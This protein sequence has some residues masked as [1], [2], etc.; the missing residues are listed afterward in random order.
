MSAVY[1]PNADHIILFGGAKL[2]YVV[3]NQV[4]V[5]TREVGGGW[6]C[7]LLAPLGTPPPARS[8]H[9]AIFDPPGNRMIVFSGWPG[10]LNDVWELDLNGKPQW[11]RI[12]P[13]SPC[14]EPRA[15]ACGIYD[16]LRRRLVIY[17]GWNGSG[18]LSD[19][20]T[21]SLSGAPVWRGVPA[22]NPGPGPRDGMS[23]VYDAVGDRMVLI[24]GSDGLD[25][26][27]DAWTLSF[28][29]FGGSIY[30]T[31]LD[32]AGDPPP[33]SV[34]HSAIYDSLRGRI[35]VHGG[36]LGERT[37]S[38]NLGGEPSWQECVST[39][40]SPGGRIEQ[41]MVLDPERQELVT[42]GGSGASNDVWR[43]GLG[44]EPIW[45]QATPTGAPPAV[46]G[47]AAAAYDPDR[48]QMIV[49]G[50]R[51][52]TDSAGTWSLSLEGDFSWTDEPAAEVAPGRHASLLVY[53]PDVHQLLRFGGASAGLDEPQPMFSDVWAT[54]AVAPLAWKEIVESNGLPGSG[55]LVLDSRR[56]RFLLVDSRG[57][58][59][60]WLW[61]LVTESG[62]RW[63]QIPVAGD[64]PTPRRGP[65]VVYDPVD[66]RLIVFGGYVRWRGPDTP[67]RRVW[68]LRLGESP[69]EWRTLAVEGEAPTDRE[70]CA[71]AYDPVWNR[72]VVAGGDVDTEAYFE[73]AWALEL[74]EKPTWRRLPG[75]GSDNKHWSQ[76]A[77]YDPIGSRMLMIGGATGGGG[78]HEDWWPLWALSL[79]QDPNWSRVPL[80]EG[81]PT[82]L[83]TGRAVYD[84]AQQRLIAA[85]ARWW[86][87]FEVS[88]LD[89]QDPMMWRTMSPAGTPPPPGWGPWWGPLLA[90]DPGRRRVLMGAVDRFWQIDLSRVVAVG[91]S[92]PATLG[93][94]G[95]SPNPARDDVRIAFSLPSA[96]PAAL[97]MFDVA[98]RRVANVA[99]GRLGPGPHLVSVADPRRLPAGLY[100]L[101]LSQGG[102]MATGTVAVV[103]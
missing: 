7:D 1:D 78:S 51:A 39:T 68:E 91:P 54:S 55:S 8:S 53:R 95:A 26:F 42:Y 31:R 44:P 66:D 69:L 96:E 76:A 18:M 20:W 32:P 16:P 5:L 28:G 10:I 86:S 40:P 101:R 94:R 61:E 71:L 9:V 21:L 13:P 33:A 27:D 47:V 41:A 73:D 75:L 23:A 63:R 52:G 62:L 4:H 43:L 82:G 30:W 35:L 64:A 77:V 22:A 24:G 90:Y 46:D 92:D 12:D 99:V 100:L 70:D 45:K 72:I 36:G 74:G 49:V 103:R 80:P 83:W 14:P 17:G 34:F 6:R 89:L 19:C 11:A 98:G 102:R 37:W 79:G 15:Y 57:Y 3:N 59:G 56:G 25:G 85:G 50:Q 87:E 84:P 93:L 81:F 38:L 48:H 65:A 67:F 2:N 88:V 29:G 97:E 58:A 60:T